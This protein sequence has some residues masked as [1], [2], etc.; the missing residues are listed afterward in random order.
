M[1][2]N[3]KVLT[4]LEEMFT[5]RELSIALGMSYEWTRK[6]LQRRQI[7]YVKLGRSVRIPRSEAARL[8]RENTVPATE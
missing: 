6:K 3:R 8:I 1:E 7:S 5:P 2:R 4:E